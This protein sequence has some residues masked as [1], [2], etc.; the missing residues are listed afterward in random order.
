M[1]RGTLIPIGDPPDG[2]N[3]TGFATVGT[4]PDASYMLVFRELN[5]EEDWSVKIPMSEGRSPR[6]TLLAGSG[7][8]KVESGKLLVHVPGTLQYLWIRLDY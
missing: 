8:A 2:A 6:V 5:A 7:T 4:K 1:Y 3:W